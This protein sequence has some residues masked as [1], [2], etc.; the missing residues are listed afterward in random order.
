M[1]C[2]IFIQRLVILFNGTEFAGMSNHVECVRIAFYVWYYSHIVV[3]HI[4]FSDL[5]LVKSTLG[6]HPAF[7]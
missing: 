3:Y 1:V 4:F 5:W 2:I 6:L 7:S